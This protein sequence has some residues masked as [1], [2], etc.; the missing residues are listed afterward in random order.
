MAATSKQLQNIR[1]YYLSEQNTLKEAAYDSGKGWYDGGMSS[2]RFPVAPYSKIAASILAGFDKIVLRVY[3]QMED[4]TI[5][6]YGWDSTF[7][8]DLIHCLLTSYSVGDGSGWRKM[9]NL[10]A[11]MPGT[12]IGCTSYKT[13]QLSIR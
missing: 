3:A 10:G 9:T 5:Q 11:A 13:S 12:H 7:S 1:V 8:I 2:Q 6:E 4:N